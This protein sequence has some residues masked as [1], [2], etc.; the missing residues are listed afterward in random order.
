MRITG[1]AARDK[2]GETIMAQANNH[3]E[4]DQA[5]CDDCG[6][7]IWRQ[8]EDTDQV[9]T[10]A[11]CGGDHCVRCLTA[12]ADHGHLCVGCIDRIDN[13]VETREEGRP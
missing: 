3:A 4:P 13:V 1:N 12:T 9:T 10:C 6:H 7:T 11:D 8:H 5:I 2:R